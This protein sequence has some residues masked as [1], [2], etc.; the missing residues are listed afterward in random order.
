MNITARRD[1]FIQAE[2]S[3]WAFVSGRLKP[4]PGHRAQTGAQDKAKCHSIS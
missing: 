3:L 2:A 4:R 1:D